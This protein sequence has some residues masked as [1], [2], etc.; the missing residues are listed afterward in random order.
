MK[1]IWSIVIVVIGSC[2]LLVNAKLGESNGFSGE[3]A[4]NAAYSSSTSNLT[5]T[6]DE[7]KVY[8][9]QEQQST[10][11]LVLPL[12]NL[13]YTFG[14]TSNQQLFLG[15]SR[16]DI[17]VGT[18]ALEV[19][20]KYR[21]EHGTR[22]SLSL[23]P[24]ILEG[25]VWQD[26]YSLSAR[27]TTNEKGMA[28]RLQ[29]NNIAGSLFSIDLAY[30]KRDIDNERSGLALVNGNT[31]NEEQ[32]RMLD[33]NADILYSKFKMML[34]ISRQVLLY[35]ALIY[36]KQDA[37]GTAMTS[38][39]Y[40]AEISSFVSAGNHQFA[41]TFS[42]LNRKYS[43]GNPVFAN[44]TQQDDTWKAFIAYEYPGIFNVE[45]L[46]LVSFAGFNN[47]QSNIAFYNSNSWI[48]AL[49]LNW[50]F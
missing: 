1:R 11:A 35:P 49:G 50:T 19:G 8:R 45:Q 46:S 30:G 39:T 18:L 29:L 3:I 20:Y 15:T 25:E 14:S 36:T 22:L 4:V 37:E 44:V 12:G 33:R 31:L 9:G 41:L 48:T 5:N 2:P 40:G 16:A 7:F 10:N 23:L 6:D 26:P 13:Q 28:Y 43:E 47:S 17:A 21:F 38:D 34:P 27:E 24:T 42:Y 32:S